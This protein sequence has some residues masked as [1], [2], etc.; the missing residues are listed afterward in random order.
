MK[1]ALSNLARGAR[2]FLSAGRV[3]TPKSGQ[4]CPRSYPSAVEARNGRNKFVL[5]SCQWLAR[6][7]KIAGGEIENAG[8]SPN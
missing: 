8:P 3:L 5:F 1:A 2:T 7:P 4:E 6:G